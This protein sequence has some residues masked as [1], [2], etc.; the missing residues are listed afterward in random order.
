[1]Y[2]CI[3]CKCHRPQLE[4][5]ISLLLMACLQMFGV[6]CSCS[7]CY[8][9]CIS[10]SRKLSSHWCNVMSITQTK[11]CLV[12]LHKIQRSKKKKKKSSSKALILEVILTLFY[13]CSGKVFICALARC[14]SLL[15]EPNLYVSLCSQF[16]SGFSIIR[17]KEHT[18]I[19]SPLL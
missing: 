10:H 11:K 4:I 16:Y 5:R 15:S 2:S 13:L 17:Y 18:S 8:I 6:F 7:Y 3:A 19:Q 1:M 12:I 14:S 9:L